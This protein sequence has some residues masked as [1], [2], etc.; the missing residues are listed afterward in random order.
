M[1]SKNELVCFEEK[2][3][4]YE[5]NESSKNIDYLRDE[6]RKFIGYIC[7]EDEC[8]SFSTA[9][10]INLIAKNVQYRRIVSIVILR[11]L[12]IENLLPENN[13]NNQIDRSIV[14]LFE[15]SIP[16]ICDYFKISEKKQ[17]YEKISIF[18]T[19]HHNILGKIAVLK[20][21]P[22]RLDGVKSIQSELF[23]SINSTIVKS[24]LNPYD[25]DTIRLNIISII[26]GI[27]QIDQIQDDYYGITLKD[28][29]DFIETQILFC[30]EN[31]TFFNEKYYLPFLGNIKNLI[32]IIIDNSKARFYCNIIPQSGNLIEKNYPLYESGRVIKVPAVFIN[33]GPGTALNVEANIVVDNENVVIGSDNISIGNIPKGRFTIL[34]E[35]LIV[36]KTRNI[37]LLIDL[38]WNRASSTKRLS[39]SVDAQIDSQSQNVDWSLLKQLEPYSTEVAEGNEFIG[40]KEKVTS[41]SNRFLKT[42]MQST[43]ITG[44]KR[45]GKTSLALAI[46]DNIKS[47]NG[48]NNFEFCY[49]EWGDYAHADPSK[50]VEALGNSLSEFLISFIPSEIRLPELD[51]EGTLAPLNKL[52]TILLNVRKEKKFI[53]ILDEFDEIHQEMYRYGPLAET[54]FSNIRSLSAK[55]NIAFILVGGEKMPFIISA[56][57]DQLNKFIHEPL[58]YFNRTDEWEDYVQLIKSPVDNKIVWYDTA[59]TD[60]YN[61]TNGQPYYTKL[62]CSRIFSNARKDRDL[63]ITANEVDKALKQEISFIDS[64]VFAHIWKDGILADREEIPIF[65]AIRCRFLISVARTLRRSEALIEEL[66]YRNDYTKRLQEHEIRPLLNDFRRRGIFIGQ[67]GT[68]DF[69]LPIFRDWLMEKGI[70]KLISDKLSE[71]LQ[72]KFQ[73]EEDEAYVT[74]SEIAEL[75]ENFASYKGQKITSED[76]R[77]WLQQVDKYTEQ[78]LLF[79]I[80]SNLRFFSEYE[81]R[82]KLKIAHSLILP[83][84]KP[85]VRKQKSD[86][87]TDILI[88]YVDGPGKSGSYYALRYAEENLIHS[89]C[90]IEPSNLTSEMKEIENNDRELGG[91][92]IIDDIAASGK[93]LSG[94]LTEFLSANN[95]IIE[96]KLPIIVVVITATK[97]GEDFVRKTISDINYNNIDFRICEPIDDRYFAFKMGNKI[98]KDDNEL[99]RAKMMCQKIGTQVYKKAPIGY[100]RLGLLVVFPN[101][102]PNNSLP[103]LHS[104]TFKKGWRPLFPRAKN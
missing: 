78:R 62:L 44:Q 80:L 15:E 25:Y 33:E 22:S 71:E 61:L 81:I 29:N 91:L 50:T 88:T 86:R 18:R 47:L 92:V 63:E 74:S 56:Q 101:T 76:V 95:S 99:E 11:C 85:F 90:V 84:I 3:L 51:F 59:I 12:S 39:L 31:L 75:T 102:C 28:Q 23:R 83:N 77:G 87:R 60:L 34:L 21:V 66:I 2:I 97:D 6:L 103:I 73:S 65:E 20:S 98:W 49:L 37:S 9:E 69:R 70:K 54:F 36:E 67:E 79:K 32:D 1:Y 42:R 45:V 24:Y 100:E 19:V 52:S 16:D 17:N 30:K 53:F 104:G 7:D 27:L 55:K 96:N 82:E 57:G 26:N 41:I 5:L 89:K 10:L 46:R 40:R 64:N 35:F 94:N 48:S 13:S 93:Q 72:E 8:L 38:N 68:F 14:N 43:Y 58:D 4:K